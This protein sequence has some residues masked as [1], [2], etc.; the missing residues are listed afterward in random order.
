M[1]TGAAA[2][3]CSNAITALTSLVANN[4]HA[5]YLEWTRLGIAWASKPLP[6]ELL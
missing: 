1:A 4:C 2:I 3:P 6:A 5:A